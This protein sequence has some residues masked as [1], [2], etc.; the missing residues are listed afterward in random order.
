LIQTIAETAST[1]TDLLDRLRD[2]ERIPE[3]LW[4]VADRQ[5]AGRGRQGRAWSGGQGNFM[6]STVVHRLAGDP[7]APTLAL[8]AGL[9]LHEAAAPLVPDASRLRLKWPNDL[10]YGPAKLAGIL[11]EGQGSAV[12]VGIGV[13]LAVA[14]DLPGR[15][16]RAFAAFGPVPDRDLFAT[17]LAQ[18]FDRELTRWRTFGLEPM[19]RRWSAAA[20]PSGTA[21]TVHDGNAAPVTGTFAGLAPDGSLLLHL[22]DGATRA[23]HAGDVMLADERI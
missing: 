4:L 5:N 14:P 23:I 22:P 9:A 7:P 15:P 20:L 17:T 10:L 16:T 6:G 2:G 19:I 1:N 13:N 21:L 11:L 18:L 3:G 12:V 8:L